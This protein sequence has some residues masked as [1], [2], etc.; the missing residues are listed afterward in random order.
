MRSCFCLSSLSLREDHFLNTTA[1][2]LSTTL[3]ACYVLVFP[4][5]FPLP[6]G[7]TTVTGRVNV[8]GHGVAP[9]GTILAI[10]TVRKTAEGISLVFITDK[11]NTG[12][13]ETNMAQEQSTL[14]RVRILI[15]QLNNQHLIQVHR[16]AS[17]LSLPRFCPSS[18][19]LKF[20]VL[21]YS[22]YIIKS[23]QSTGP[24]KDDVVGNVPNVPVVLIIGIKL[25]TGRLLTS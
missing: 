18:Y 8:V 13:F 5:S 6:T 22:S 25:K 17:D 1:T 23:N 14:E 16:Q 15:L 10:D 9:E 2:V 12:T 11:D 7:H 4:P 19:F 24:G 3:V 20:A 21:N